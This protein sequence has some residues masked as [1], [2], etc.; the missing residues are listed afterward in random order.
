M[1]IYL[2]KI[3]GLGLGVVVCTVILMLKRLQTED[4]LEVQGSLGYI[5]KLLCLG[6]GQMGQMGKQWK[7]LALEP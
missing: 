4:C 1:R 2:N 7:Q 6:R 5:L 3:K